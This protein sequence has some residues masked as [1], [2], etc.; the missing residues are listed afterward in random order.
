MCYCRIPYHDNLSC[1]IY[2]LIKTVYPPSFCRYDALC[3]EVEDEVV[4]SSDSGGCKD[5]KF[6]CG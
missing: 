4:I 2:T 5:L 3:D 6:A 1:I